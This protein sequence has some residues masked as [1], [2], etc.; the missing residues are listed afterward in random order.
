MCKGQLNLEILSEIDL[1]SLDKKSS[2][3]H[4]LGLIMAWL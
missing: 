3:L 2:I 1:K 4:P